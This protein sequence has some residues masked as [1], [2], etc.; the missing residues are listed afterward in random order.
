MATSSSSSS[1]Y[2]DFKTLS[3]V[4]MDLVINEID[5]ALRIAGKYDGKVFGGYVRG[6]LVPRD[7]NPHCE[8]SFKDVD[9]WFTDSKKAEHFISEMGSNFKPIPEFTTTTSDRHYPF[10]RVQYHYFVNGICIAWFDLIISET[11]PVDDFDVNCLTFGYVDGHKCWDVNERLQMDWTHPKT[12][13][14]FPMSILKD[15]IMRKEARLLPSIE[16]LFFCSPGNISR[17]IVLMHRFKKR[18]HQLGWKI[19][20]RSIVCPGS[21]LDSSVNFYNWLLMIAR[22]VGKSTTPMTEQQ[23]RVSEPVMTDM[24]ITDGSESSLSKQERIKEFDEFLNEIRTRFL[25]ALNVRD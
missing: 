4:T 18:Y 7:F 8:V 14:P 15:R 6:V 1:S 3:G 25:D 24:K 21:N 11:F 22:S 10:N 5:R 16:T 19:M 9:L 12:N 20:Y 13:D 17:Q 23:G 2:I